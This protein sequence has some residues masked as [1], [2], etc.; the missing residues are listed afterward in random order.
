[1]IALR[2]LAADACL[3]IVAVALAAAISACGSSAPA[4]TAPSGRPSSG[5]VPSAGSSAAPI[6]SAALTPVPGGPTGPA[7]GPTVGPPTTTDTEIGPIF[8]ELPPSFPILNGAEPGEIGD[9]PNSGSYAVNMSTGDAS[10]A[11]ATALTAS[12][13]V[14]DVGSPLED[15]TVVLDATHD[16]AGCRTEVR[17]TPLS[18]TVVMSVLYGASCPFS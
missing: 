16:P 4:T 5:P 12:G 7:L 2:R 15:G 17:F 6:A 9:G 18:G 3:P 13:W 8:D 10:R 1:M 11:I 14:V